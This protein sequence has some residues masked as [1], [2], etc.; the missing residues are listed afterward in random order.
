[1]FRIEDRAGREIASSELQPAVAAH[2]AGETRDRPGRLKAVQIGRDR[3]TF[4][5][6][7][8]DLQADVTA[9]VGFASNRFWYEPVRSEGRAAADAHS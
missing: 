1:M 4:V 3:A 2:V 7:R 5:Y 6:T 8:E 9:E